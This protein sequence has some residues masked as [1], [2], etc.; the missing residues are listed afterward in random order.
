MKR[1]LFGPVNS[2]RLG[3]S[4]GIDLLPFKTCTL[5]CVYCECGWTTDQTLRRAELVPT[6]QVIAELDDYLAARPPLDYV[7]FSGAGEPT[8][9]TGI[10]V[11]IGHLKRHYPHYPVAV[12]T[13]G[14]LLGDP[15]VQAQLAAAD[16]VVPSLDGA[17]PAA[18]RAICRPAAGLTV[19]A[20][21][22]GIAAFRRGFPGLLLLEVFLVPGQNDRP[23]E[24][25]ALKQA[26]TLIAPDAIQ[27]NSLDR[28]APHPGV[29]PP[30]DAAL[31]RVRD[32]LYPLQVQ[33]VRRRGPGELAPWDNPELFQEIAAVLARGPTSLPRLAVATGIRA[34]DLA[35]TL[36]QM[37]RQ[38]LVQC[39]HDRG[40]WCIAP[41]YDA[42]S[43]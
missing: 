19:D 33:A 10:G 32:F 18:F 3:R 40:E 35:K 9:H 23:E 27:L 36:A 1:F 39:R 38:S 34:S 15:E 24:L 6:H 8:L 7:T 16:L 43:E 37:V 25:A 5:D 14:T 12:L 22:E 26:A 28:P 4:L 42:D 29:A 21:I 13:N 30:G 41:M 31:Q 11:V 17:T 2:R 20:V